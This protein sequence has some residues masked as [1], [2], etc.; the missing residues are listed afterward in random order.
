[1]PRVFPFE[2]LV[3]DPAVAGP[4][5]R[6]T[7]PPYDVISETRRRAALAEPYS[8]VRVDLVSETDGGAGDGYREAG[9]LLERWVDERALVRTPAA[10]HAYEMS[11]PALGRRARVRGLL[12]AMELEAWGRGV[13]PH[14]RTMPGPL[15][16]R[17]RLLRATRTH[18]S[19]V[20][21]TIAGPSD[22]LAELLARV[23]STP[24]DAEVVDEQAIRH[25]R[26]TLP[27]DLPVASWLAEEPV[28]I[29]D[30]HHRYTTALAYRD[31]MRA[32]HGSGT[33]DRMLTLIVDAGTEHLPV[34]PFHRLQLDGTTPPVDGRQVDGL[35][36]ALTWISDDEPTVCVVTR[37]PGGLSFTLVELAGEA[38]AV[39]ALHEEILDGAVPTDRLRYTP[40]PGEA[41]EAVRTGRAAAAYLLPA[42]TPDR[43]RKVV[44]RGER[45]PQKSTYFWPKPR[46]GMML[47]PLDAQSD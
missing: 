28:L 33:W 30:G 32:R 20:Y 34:R 37:T 29:A 14:E 22:D 40:D 46:T 2:G 19:A 39:R 7:A 43:I 4:L 13:L 24:P 36:E 35:P 10:F 17:L 15:D 41:V 38:P 9:A 27:A 5:D 25:R 21:G 26:W 44:E 11:G 23:T 18:L 16:D 1:V 45:L 42:T 8:I 3:Y 6:V 47:M 12:C 31:E